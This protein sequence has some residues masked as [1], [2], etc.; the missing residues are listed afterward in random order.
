MQ[1]TPSLRYSLVAQFLFGALLVLLIGL[2]LFY[3]MMQPPLQEMG[4]MTGLMGGTGLLSVIAAYLGYRSGWIIYSPRLRWTL[5]A[6]YTFA[7]LLAFLN[8]WI[9]AR[10][11]FLN[12]HDLMLAT[13][14]LVFS[15]GIAVVVGI[16]LSETITSRIQQLN[17]AASQV[18]R[19]QLN[20]RLAV[21]GRDEMAQLAKS[22]NEMVTQLETAERKKAEVEALRRDLVAWAGHD[23]RTPLTSIRAII[24]SLA[25]GVV[26]DEAARQRY[27]RT[28]QAGIESLSHLIDDLFE[29]S[30]IDAG[31]MKMDLGPGY[32]ADLV[33]DALERF[34]E[35][36]RQKNI[37]L[38][39][40]ISPEI[41]MVR[42]D[43]KRIGRV[44]A[45]LLG[46]ALRHTPPGGEVQVVAAKTA[47]GIQVAVTD[48]GEGIR[49]EDLPY[50][51]EQ[52]Y[53]GEKS[54]NRTTGGAGLGLA[55]ARGI[56]EAH[57]GSIG[58]E[59]QVGQGTRVWFCLPG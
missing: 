53:R 38:E 50:V 41:G 59:S 3:L 42:M 25:D 11:M 44:L 22:F 48:S 51:F 35:Q 47:A 26:E 13:I 9:T 32:I 56:V 46:N 6:G 29:M 36:A 12:Q 45:N 18:A 17:T 33:S 28:A 1:T 2:G 58:I 43:E 27:L 8:V 31:G 20:T 16:F 19:G 24:E 30:Q 15:T 14:L 52:F 5:A 37:R 55:I 23:L 4:L 34:S 54:R 40:K 49:A 21:A 7:G 39:G 57:G 10:M